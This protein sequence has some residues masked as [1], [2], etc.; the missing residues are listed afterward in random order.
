MQQHQP[1]DVELAGAFGEH[2]LHGLA[3][4]EQHAEGRAFGHVRD[5]HVQC[6]LGFRDVVHAVSQ[7]TVGEAVLA[8][9]EAI[10]FAA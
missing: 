2:E 8:H 4:G 5:R 3:V 9:I 6:A 10:A 1:P 7:A